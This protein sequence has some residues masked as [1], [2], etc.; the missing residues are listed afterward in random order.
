M[1]LQVCPTY[2]QTL[3]EAESPRGRISL[4]QG[5]AN[6]ELEESPRLLAHLDSCLKCRACEDVCPSDVLYGKIIDRAHDYIEANNNRSWLHRTVKRFGLGLVT[7]P[8]RLSSLFSLLRLYQRSGLQWI[9]AHSV[10]ANHSLLARLN[11][12]LAPIESS[13]QWLT[14]YEAKN[15]HI[16]NVALFTG[17]IAR[18]LDQKTLKATISVLTRLGYGVHVPAA[19]GCCGALHQHNGNLRK[20]ASLIDS[21]RDAFAELDVD[22]I[23]TTASGCGITLLESS[24]KVIDISAFLADI[25]WPENVTLSPLNKTI[26]VHDPCSLR[27]VWHEHDKPYAVLKRIPDADVI[28][29]AQND[30]CCGAAGSYMLTHADMAN[31]LRDRKLDLIDATSVDILATSNIGCALHFAAGLKQKNS[32]I[33]VVHPVVLIDRQLLN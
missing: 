16:G 26:A 21:N 8:A 31:T 33:E 6:G 10:L 14:Y 7:N 13:S 28:E 4:V 27:R 30:Q 15:A 22:A 17:C 1:C 3:N 20:S 5:L 24:N 9:A 18:A 23:I 12:T 29:L 25:N 19:Q 11:K 2:Q 32:S